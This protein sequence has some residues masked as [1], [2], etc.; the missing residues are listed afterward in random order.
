M[1]CL[2]ILGGVLMAGPSAS[3]D[4]EDSETYRCNAPGGQSGGTVFPFPSTGMVISGRISVHSA[5][6]DTQWASVVHILAH[7][8]G[9]RNADGDCGCNGIAVFAFKNPDRIEFYTT[10]NNKQVSMQRAA[11]FDTPITFQIAIDPKGLMTVTIGKT[12]PIAQTVMLRHPEHDTLELTCSGTDVSFL[13]VA[14][15]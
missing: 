4:V 6:I 7:Q 3:A 1:A 14:A 5:D 13:N 8:R 2:A 10:V 9:A 15:L 11:P 12:K